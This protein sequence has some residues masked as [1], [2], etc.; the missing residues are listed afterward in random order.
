MHFP[1]DA[2]AVAQARPYGQS[3]S[4]VHGGVLH[5]A[6]LTQTPC[7]H[8]AHPPQSLSAVQSVPVQPSFGA[9]APFTHAVHGGHAAS[10][11]HLTTGQPDEAA[12]FPS[13]QV[14][15]LPHSVLAT[16]PFSSLAVLLAQRPGVPAQTYPCGQSSATVQAYEQ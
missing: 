8:V 11:S 14:P 7:V 9:Q 12:H 13:R 2:P 3:L 1:A 10:V 15:H 4:E 16:H 6:G 5:P